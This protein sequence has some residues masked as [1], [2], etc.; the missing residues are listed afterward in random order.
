MALKTTSE[1]EGV[2]PY[3]PFGYHTF[4]K[5]GVKVERSSH[6]PFVN[7]SDHGTEKRVYVTVNTQWASSFVYYLLD[8]IIAKH[9]KQFF[10]GPQGTL[11]SHGLD[12]V[13]I[14]V[15]SAGAGGNNLKGVF[16]GIPEGYGKVSLKKHKKFP[17]LVS[18]VDGE[19]MDRKDLSELRQVR[20]VTHHINVRVGDYILAAMYDMER[21]SPCQLLVLLYKIVGFTSIVFE[22]TVDGDDKPTNHEYDVANCRL[23]STYTE[24]ACGEV[25]SQFDDEFVSEENSKKFESEIMEFVKASFSVVSGHDDD[26]LTDLVIGNNIFVWPASISAE[27][28]EWVNNACSAINALKYEGDEGGSIFKPSGDLNITED[29][30]CEDISEVVIDSDDQFNEW[31]I[32]NFIKNHICEEVK[33]LRDKA[34]KKDFRPDVARLI[35]RDFVHNSKATVEVVAKREGDVV[36][37]E[38]KFPS[39]H[40][41]NVSVMEFILNPEVHMKDQLAEYFFHGICGE[42]QPEDKRKKPALEILLEDGEESCHYVTVLLDSHG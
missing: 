33:I 25:A 4:N 3:T 35:M 13:S 14:P 34:G 17:I 38:F 27:P 32:T 20:D 22:A 21:N 16:A 23:A 6:L 37:V 36:N 9:Q 5:D 26:A 1:I 40:N 29:E 28:N 11:S 15:K 39:I 24:D 10:Q 18:A 41:R 12:K 30:E 2:V 19:T 7:V 8:K 31:P 42:V